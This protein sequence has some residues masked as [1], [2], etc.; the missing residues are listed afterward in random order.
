MTF[1]IGVLDAYLSEVSAEVLV[2]QLEN[3]HLPNSSARSMLKRIIKEVDT[4]ALELALTTDP[5]ARR[6]AARQ[7][8]LDYLTSSVSNH[9]ARA[10]A[11]TLD[12]VGSP[13]LAALWNAVDAR[14]AKWPHLAT[15]GR[16]SAAILDHW[17]GLRH[18]IVHEG[19]APQVTGDQA[20]ELIEF[21]AVLCREI[22]KRAMSA[23]AA[24]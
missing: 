16:R 23:L 5:D 17:T 22:D 6:A 8:L 10:V 3:A 14:G 11:A 4:L 7:A 18:K 24:I 9:G 21:V 15:A 19:A 13:D 2:T 12:R 20:R 1:S